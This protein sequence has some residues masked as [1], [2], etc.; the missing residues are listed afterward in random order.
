MRIWLP[1]NDGDVKQDGADAASEIICIY[2]V[3]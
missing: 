1:V 2:M 3:S